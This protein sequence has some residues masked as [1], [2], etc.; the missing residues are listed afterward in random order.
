MPRGGRRE[1]TGTTFH[2]RGGTGKATGGRS[3]DWSERF[4]RSAASSPASILIAFGIGA[5]V[6]S[7]NARSTVSDELKQQQI[8]G[9]P[10]MNPTDIQAAMKEAGIANVVRSRRATSP[11]R[12]SRPVAT[13]AASRSTCRF[14]RSR[15]RAGSCTRRWAASWR[16]ADPSSP[17]GTSDEAAALKDESGKPVANAVRNTWVTETA[18]STALN[19]S[20]MAS[21]SRCSGSSSGSRCCSAASA[22]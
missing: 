2:H 18:L 15:L 9:S 17:K 7:I 3:D 5:L 21:R 8:V 19:V 1:K 14:T 22:S 12:R 11:T 16:K 20:Y 13:R 10:D 6:M 4:S